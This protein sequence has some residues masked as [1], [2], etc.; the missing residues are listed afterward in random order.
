MTTEN[1][2]KRYKIALRLIIYSEYLF[3]DN[4]AKADIIENISL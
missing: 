1:L 3:V 2:Q 4:L